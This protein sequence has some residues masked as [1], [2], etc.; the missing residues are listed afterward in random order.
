[1]PI[2]ASMVTNAISEIYLYSVQDIQQSVTSLQEINLDCSGK[3]Q[4]ICLNCQTQAKKVLKND[5]EVASL[6]KQACTCNLENINLNEIISVNMKNG[7]YNLTD[8]KLSNT[9]IS[10]LN[11]NIKQSGDSSLAIPDTAL[12]NSTSI[13][14]LNNYLKSQTFQNSVSALSASQVISVKG[15]ANV[16][17]V[18]MFSSMN[19]VTNILQSSDTAGTAINNLVTELISST[20][21]VSEA[22]F[23]TLIMWIVKIVIIFVFI[24]AMMQTINLSFQIY[25]KISDD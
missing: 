13:Q 6:C 19:F 2:T 17:N 25:Q 14:S 23:A 20:T 22:G 4:E 21:Q 12:S 16:I 11:A 1:M 15:A 7:S 24:L 3:T 18:N 8:Q 9:I 5:S 10:I